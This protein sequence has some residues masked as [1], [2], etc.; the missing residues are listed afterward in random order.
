MGPFTYAALFGGGFVAGLIN[1]IAGGGSLISFPILLWAGLD[2]VVANATNTV[3]YSPG[4]LA[5]VFGFRR[6][7]GGLGGWMRILIPPSLAGG[8]FGA[9]LLLATPARIFSQLVPYLI[10]FATLIFGLQETIARVFRAAGEEVAHDDP[11]A[12]AGRSLAAA[13]AF[14]LV[15]AIYGGY[16]GAG[17]GI[18]LLAG[19]G[20]LGLTDIRRMMGLRNLVGFLI[21]GIAATYFVVQGAVSWAPC[22]AMMVGQIAGGYGGAAVARGVSREVVRRAVVAIGL[23]MA[24][25]LFL[26]RG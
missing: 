25:S 11:R 3:A 5:A 13:V 14:Q 6:E 20:L 22:G 2:P 9:W 21:N 16:F 24:L 12:P 7:L 8:V 4:G 26:T 23:A 15:V 19:L 1:S 17:M 10:L 18:M